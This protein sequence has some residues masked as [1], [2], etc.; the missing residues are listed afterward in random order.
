MF[1]HICMIII[2]KCILVPEMENSIT[3][4][5]IEELFSSLQLPFAHQGEINPK[6]LPV[7]NAS[8]PGE[9]RS[10]LLH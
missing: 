7:G 3:S 4:I 9:I 1:T 8:A 10:E 2:L 6:F 5:F